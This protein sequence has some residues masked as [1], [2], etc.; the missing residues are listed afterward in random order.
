M[1]R[2]IS[3]LA[4]ALSGCINLGDMPPMPGPYP[5]RQTVSEQIKPADC[6]PVISIP[7]MPK[8]MQISV[9]EGIIKADKAGE[10][11]IRKIFNAR[12]DYYKACGEPS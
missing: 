9:T 6:H 8:D 4:L 10:D 1:T 12:K 7:R 2:L 11:Y 3:C 5:M